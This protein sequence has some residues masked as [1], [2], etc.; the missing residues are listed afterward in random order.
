MDKIYSARYIELWGKRSSYDARISFGIAFF[1]NEEDADAFAEEVRKH[2]STYNGGIMHGYPLGRD[3][4][5]DS[6]KLGYAVTC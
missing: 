4:S 6:E 5:W 2:G 1:E 3:K